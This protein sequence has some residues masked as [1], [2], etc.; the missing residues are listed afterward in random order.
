MLC[1]KDGT[2]LL[3][4]AVDSNPHGGILEIPLPLNKHHMFY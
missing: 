1:H 4:I 3:Y 2:D